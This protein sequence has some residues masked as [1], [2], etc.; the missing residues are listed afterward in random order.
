[1][2]G[3][4]IEKMGVL[5]EISPFNVEIQI[6]RLFSTLQV[7]FHFRFL[8][9]SKE[10]FWQT[11]SKPTS[12]KALTSSGFSATLTVNSSLCGSNMVCSILM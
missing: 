6:T 9:N 4:N 3:A 10:S 8:K 2:I 7:G 11:Y 12:S 5:R 1:M